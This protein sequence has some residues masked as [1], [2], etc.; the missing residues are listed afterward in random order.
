MQLEKYVPEFWLYNFG[1]NASE[2]VLLPPRRQITFEV[3]FKPIIMGPLYSHWVLRNNLTLVE[4][5]TFRGTGGKGIL[6][7]PLV[8]HVITSVNYA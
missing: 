3:A 6:T 8:G 4:L 5:V 1:G 2:P 7:I